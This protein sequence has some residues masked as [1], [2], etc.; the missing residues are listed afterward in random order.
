MKHHAT[1]DELLEAVFSVFRTM[2]IA[3]QRLGKHVSAA[4][5]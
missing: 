4:I 5:V 2:A 3:T 1:T